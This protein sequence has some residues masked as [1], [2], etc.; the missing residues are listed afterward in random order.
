[1]TTTTTPQQVPEN[2]QPPVPPKHSRTFRIFRAAGITVGTL[3]AVGVIAGSLGA[4][5]KTAATTTAP[6]AAA[7][8]APATVTHKAAPA[9]TVTVTAAPAKTVT[10][11]A[12]RSTT[13]IE[14]V[15]AAAPAVPAYQSGNCTSVYNTPLYAGPDTS[16]P[17]AQNVE[18]AY[19][20]PGVEYVTS[21]VTGGTYAM[22]CEPAGGSMYSVTCT[23]GNNAL[24][25]F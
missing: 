18:S 15:P 11:P 3:V 12:P 6:K 21:P 23:G 2:T 19:N 1:M 24:V 5:H 17:F 4:S 16:C 14:Q 25:Q 9:P 22:D 7:V 20:G 13:I 8:S 10:A